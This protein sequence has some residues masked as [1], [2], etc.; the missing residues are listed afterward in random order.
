[1]YNLQLLYS[2]L[3]LISPIGIGLLLY[4]YGF[5]YFMED[6][7]VSSWMTIY[8]ISNKI[9]TGPAWFFYLM[10]CLGITALFICFANSKKVMR[11]DL[12]IPISLSRLKG[13]SIFILVVVLGW[14]IVYVFYNGFGQVQSD[15]FYS[16]Y[17]VQEELKNLG[18]PGI[19]IIQSLSMSVLYLSL[20]VFACIDDSKNKIQFMLI[21]L[22]LLISMI[23]VNFVLSQR[24]LLFSSLSSFLFY[25]LFYRKIKYVWL[26]FGVGIFYFVWVYTETYVHYGGEGFGGY[27]V[28]IFGYGNS[29]IVFYLMN[30]VNN[31]VAACKNIF[32]VMDS[33][34][35]RLSLYH[36]GLNRIILLSDLWPNYQFMV[37]G[38]GGGTPTLFGHMVLDFGI[39][40]PFTVMIL[41]YVL[42]KNAISFGH[43]KFST[44]FFPVLLSVC[45]LGIHTYY[46][47][48]E[49]FLANALIL[50][51]ISK[52]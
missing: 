6:R 5:E 10:S 13:V 11:S 30:N 51:F 32:E 46:I 34:W 25:L 39:F 21:S 35:G 49:I 40:M 9:S 4:E 1:M 19:R 47:F 28:D 15:A 29:K 26:L 41:S 17:L 45:V 23:L 27:L 42:F 36:L 3:V 43:G 24:V 52:K 38:M 37:R 18:F 48:H 8:G 22:F 31:Y 14:F 20:V 12:V 50:L 44:I 7:V 2:Y 16:R 33:G